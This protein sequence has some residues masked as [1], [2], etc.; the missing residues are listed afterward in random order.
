MAASKNL[1]EDAYPQGVF[2]DRDEP[3]YTIS[4][5][6]RLVRPV[7]RDTG[8]A[9]RPLHAQTLRMYEREGLI[10]PKRVGRNRLYS[11]RDIERLRQIQHFTQELGVNLAGVEIILDLMEQMEDLKRKLDE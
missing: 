9:A 10:K 5:A 8:R 2:K 7:S 3:I 11:D 4:I 1:Q 6:T